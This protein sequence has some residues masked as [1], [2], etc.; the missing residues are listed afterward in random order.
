VVVD[1][2]FGAEKRLYA[3]QVN[4]YKSLLISMG[5]GS[6]SGFLWYVDNDKII[7]V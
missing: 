1:F 6:V 4:N 2:K 7:E 5:Y 3:D